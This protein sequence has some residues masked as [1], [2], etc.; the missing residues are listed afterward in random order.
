MDGIDICALDPG[1]EPLLGK[2]ND[3]ITIDQEIEIA[4]RY[5]IDFFNFLIFFT[6]NS[7]ET[8]ENAVINRRLNAPIWKF[9]KSPNRSAMQ[10]SVEWVN[11]PP[12]HELSDD[13]W[14]SFSDTLC[15]LFGQ[16]DYLS[17]KDFCYFK[18]HSWHYWA[19]SG[20]PLEERRAR[21]RFL[22]SRVFEKTGKTLLVG[23]GIRRLE[24]VC[25]RHPIV[26]E[27]L[28]DWTGIYV[29]VPGMVANA[30]DALPA[31]DFPFSKLEASDTLGRAFHN[32]DYLAHL[33]NVTTGFSPLWHFQQN[34]PKFCAPTPNELHN[35]VLGA[36]LDVAQYTS[37]G[38]PS[39]PVG[40]SSETVP[41]I[42]CYAWNEYAEGGILAPTKGWG[43]SR[44]E[45]LRSTRLSTAS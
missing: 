16:S 40:V 22:K 11:H 9:L 30:P 27:E 24:T 12:F 20:L 41:A 10:F 38:L 23:A 28:F 18:V 7:P 32:N 35:S 21:M 43:L 15:D 31:K 44:L 14:Q 34:L 6:K 1:R 2:Y 8:D 25:E 5:G 36:L 33:P 3:Q 39:G 26:S 42:T 29:D 19:V 37:L 45:A 13:E 17:H 4:S